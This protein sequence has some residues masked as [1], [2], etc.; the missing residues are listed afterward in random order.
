MHRTASINLVPGNNEVIFEGLSNFID[1]SSIEV[2]GQGNATI[3]SVNYRINYLKMQQETE[4]AKKLKV[5]VDSVNLKLELVRNEI[6]VYEQDAAL[7]QSNFK[8]GVNAKTEFTDDVEEWAERFRKKELDIKNNITKLTIESKALVALG[9]EFESELKQINSSTKEPSGEIVVK[10]SSP[11]GGNADFK[12]AYYVPNAGW[13][14][15]YSLRAQNTTDPIK[16]DYDAMVSQNTGEIWKDIK[17]TLSTGNPMLGGNKPELSTWY[18]NFLQDVYYAKKAYTRGYGT[19]AK[20]KKEDKDGKDGNISGA[21]GEDGFNS[22]AYLTTSADYT[23]STQS[24]LNVNFE[25]NLRYTIATDGTPQQVKIQQ[26]TLPALYEYIASPKLDKDAFLLARATGWEDDNLLPGTANLYYEGAYIGK[27]FINPT[28]TNDTLDLSFGRDKKINIDRKML[29]DF[30][31]KSFLGKNKTQNFVYEI[32]LKNTK[33]IPVSI[34][35]EDQV[36]V[37][38]TKEVEVSVKEISKA[39]YDIKTGKLQWKLTMQ[40]NEVKKLKI[41]YSVK[42]PKNKVVSGL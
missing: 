37:S 5:S 22:E 2:Q 42:Y 8:I 23:T 34:T 28:V 3:L 21:R 9:Y 30:S 20:E 12:F 7:L 15:L 32:S 13:T 33:N 11:S 35:I 25:I 39:D 40:P 16:L 27:S 29:R 10:V 1:E 17:M 19:E 31:K 41:E 38:Q 4:R 18:L 6:S 14:P 26:S 24:Q 36:P